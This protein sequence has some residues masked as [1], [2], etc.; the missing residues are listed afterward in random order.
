[1]KT[2]FLFKAFIS[3]L[4]AF[5]VMTKYLFEQYADMALAGRNYNY[6]IEAGMSDAFLYF[7]A[8]V[9]IGIVVWFIC[10]L[11]MSFIGRFLNRQINGKRR[12]KKEDKEGDV[13]HD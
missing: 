1:M 12:A 5:N 13:F 3:L 2:S 7:L 6:G 8:A 11:V 9:V 4:V 10:M